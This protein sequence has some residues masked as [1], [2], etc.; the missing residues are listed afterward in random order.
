MNVNS[1]SISQSLSE[2]VHYIVCMF[3]YYDITRTYWG[4]PVLCDDIFI[5]FINRRVFQRPFMCANLADSLLS[6][7]FNIYLVNKCK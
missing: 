3:L 2:T 5:I 6:L 7:Q 4:P 1:V